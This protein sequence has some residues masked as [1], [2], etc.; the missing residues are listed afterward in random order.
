MQREFSLT[1]FKWRHTSRRYRWKNLKSGE[2]KKNRERGLQPLPR[3]EGL[4]SCLRSSP[5]SLLTMKSSKR[6]R[7]RQKKCITLVNP[8]QKWVYLHQCPA[9][10]RLQCLQRLITTKVREVTCIN[11]ILNSPFFPSDE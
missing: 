3:P 1:I 11:D 5:P 4:T 6:R 10:C 9:S 7:K 8:L 2:S